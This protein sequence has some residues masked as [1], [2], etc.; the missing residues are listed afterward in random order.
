MLR[1]IQ[2]MRMVCVL[3]ILALVSLAQTR[4]VTDAE[5]ERVHH[6]AILIDTHNDITSRTVDGYDIGKNKNDGHTNIAALKEGGVGAQFFAV[7]VSSS[8]VNGNHSANRTLQM[9][10]TVRHDIVERYSGDFVLATTADDIERIHKQG[11]IAALM[12]IEGGHA[13]EDSLRL[14]RDY[15]D[16]GIR[17]MTLTHTNTNGW[18]DSSGDVDKAGVEHHNGLTPFGKLVV[19]EMNRLGMMIDISHTADKTFWDALATSTAPIIASHS[20]CRALCNVPRNMT[21]EMIAA[22]GKK[23]GVMQIN[24]NC[25]FLSEK[26]AA[27]A[28]NVQEST[29]PGAR[30]EDATIAE[31]KKKVPPA[32]LEDVVA[33]I[34]HAVKVGGIGAV[35]IGSDFDGVSCTPTGLEDVSKFPNLTRALLQ[36]GYSAEDI[37]KIYGGNT[38]R[39]MRAVEAEAKRAQAEKSASN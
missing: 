31:Y 3:M 26:S 29:L 37:R 33:H 27:A 5:V 19:R 35:G 15:F 9:I 4:P 7:Y 36:K 20:S 24:F 16:L 39:V 17:Y 28:K 18:A 38:M 10:D 25:G 30:G 22:L 6:S 8:Y 11:K 34:D 1:Y 2:G 32:T 13:I 23:G 14:L 12:G 21:D